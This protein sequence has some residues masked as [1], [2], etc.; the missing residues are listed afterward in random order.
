MSIYCDLCREVAP[1][2]FAYDKE[3]G[4]AYVFKQP[5]SE[6]EHELAKESLE[7]CP[8]ESIG[9]MDNPGIEYCSGSD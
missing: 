3:F 9:D 1:T 4:I 5:E 2:V 8:T 6:E 7:G